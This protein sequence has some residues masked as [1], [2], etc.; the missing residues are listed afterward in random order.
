M[1]TLE[2]AQLIYQMF[3]QAAMPG[4]RAKQTAASIQE[5]LVELYPKPEDKDTEG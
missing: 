1:F 2:E 5:K 4:P 3:E